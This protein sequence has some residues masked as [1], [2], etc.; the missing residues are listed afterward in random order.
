MLL[1][2]GVLALKPD[3]LSG[4]EVAAVAECGDQHRLCL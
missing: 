1:E 4:E 3:N 2:T